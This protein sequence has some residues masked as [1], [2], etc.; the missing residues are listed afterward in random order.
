ME[1]V[2][3]N[4]FWFSDSIFVFPASHHGQVTSGSNGFFQAA[5]P[6]SLEEHYIPQEKQGAYIFCLKIGLKIVEFINNCNMG[7][8]LDF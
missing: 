8:I 2:P 3:I 4:L 5:S 6:P 7:P 1:Y